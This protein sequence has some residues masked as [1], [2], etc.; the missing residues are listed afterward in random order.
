[1]EQALKVRDGRL[2]DGE[3]RGEEVATATRVTPSGLIG[4]RPGE[5][6]WIQI[7]PLPET[8]RPCPLLGTFLQLTCEG[9]V[10]GGRTCA[11]ALPVQTPPPGGP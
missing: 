9:L 2:R 1:M 11:A 4:F 6:H 8:T 5:G 7:C 3:G 10:E